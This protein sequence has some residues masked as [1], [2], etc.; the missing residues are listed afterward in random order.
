MPEI[1]QLACPSCGARLDV[2]PGVA[3]IR[4]DYCQTTLAVTHERG[5][6]GLEIARELVGAV[7]DEQAQMRASLDRSNLL[8]ERMVASQRLAEVRT[9]LAMLDG[10]LRNLQQV[11]ATRQSRARVQHLHQI[12]P[13]IA[14]RHDAIVR[15][16]ARIDAILNPQPAAQPGMPPPGTRAARPTPRA[17]SGCGTVI[18]ILLII[19]AVLLAISY[20]SPL[21][22]VAAA[23]FI[24]LGWLR[25][26]VVARV[27]ASK[28]FAGLPSAL[29]GNP[30]AFAVV[31]G[32]ILIVASLIFGAMTYGP[33]GYAWRTPTPVA[34][35]VATP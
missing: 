15:D 2:P 6:A 29:R 16:L 33:S 22:V 34:T 10:E 5:E 23:I 3:Q 20:L 21:T 35:K 19:G 25:P 28:H 31:F 32:A 18:V 13:Q 30:K 7:R 14:Q 11:K 17:S 8:Q 26:E 27:A 1:S 12:R 9:E 4:C 24:A